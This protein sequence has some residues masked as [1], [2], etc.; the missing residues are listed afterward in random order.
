VDRERQLGLPMRTA[1][2][3]AKFTGDPNW[4]STFV[5]R[6]GFSDQTPRLSP[7]RPIEDVLVK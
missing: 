4:R 7:R 2:A 6:M 1:E 3:L 5:F